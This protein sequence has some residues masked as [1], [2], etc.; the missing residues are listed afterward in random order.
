VLRITRIESEDD[1]TLVLEGKLHAAWLDELRA[2]LA[3]ARTDK[4]VILDLAALSF[5]DSSGVRFLAALQ[6]DGIALH[7]PTALISALIL[8]AAI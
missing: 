7:R 6:R 2:A 3:S 5:A 8:T 1:V 4:P